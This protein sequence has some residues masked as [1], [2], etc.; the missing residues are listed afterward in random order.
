[1]RIT[2]AFF[3]IY[4]LS[5]IVESFVNSVRNIAIIKVRKSMGGLEM[6]ELKIF[7]LFIVC[8]L[9]VYF[10]PNEQVKADTAA[11]QPMYRLYNPNSSEH[12][13][14]AS[15]Y[16]RDS[17][18]KV[19]WSDERLGWIAPT[20]TGANVYRLYNPNSGDHHYTTSLNEKNQLVKIGWRYE[21]VGWRS[22]E[23]KK[24]PLYRLYNP[25]VKVGT[26]HYTT[27]LAEKNSLVQLGWRDEGIAWYGVN[28]TRQEQYQIIPASAPTSLVTSTINS[29]K[30]FA[31]AFGEILN[32]YRVSLNLSPLTVDV[33]LF[34]A[35]QVRSYDLHKFFEHLRP[36]GTQFWTALGND[37][38]HFNTVG[39]NIEYAWGSY[40]NR[41]IQQTAQD[42]FDGWKNSPNHHQNMINNWHSFGIGLVVDTKNKALASS[43]LLA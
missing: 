2:V 28:L 18:V 23:Q 35:A 30:A 12:F 6:K 43:L 14:T 1:M 37:R 15:T 3:V 32:R 33:Y 41:S 34:D 42:M 29:Q 22:D 38:V 19:G 4:F 11:A 36:D 8:G 24:I 17:L 10:L 7:L 31:Q 40:Y 16:E 20:T 26:H 5:Y 39:E 9:L 13:Y 25:N 27:S 21:G